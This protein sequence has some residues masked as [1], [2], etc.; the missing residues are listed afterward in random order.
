MGLLNYTTQVSA[1]KSVAEIISLLVRKGAQRVSQEYGE[2]GKIVALGF[3]LVV[4]EYPVYF[5]LP[6][7]VGATLKVMLKDKPYSYRSSGSRVQY[8][9]RM[10]E[11]AE[12]VAW[13]I[14]KDWV[15]AQLALIETGQAEMAQ[16]FMPYAQQQNGQTLYQ[17][18]LEN[19]QRMLGTG[20]AE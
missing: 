14:L 4:C 1:S 17:R 6:A 18:W 12:R 10:W 3:T 8:E 7:N 15:E 9:Q 19:G 2:G 13:R 5:A 16:V 11:Q 20:D